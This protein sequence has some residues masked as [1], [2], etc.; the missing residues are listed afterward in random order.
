MGGGTPSQSPHAATATAPASPTVDFPSLYKQEFAYAWRTLRRLGVRERDL[1]DLAHDLF[2]VVFRHLSDYDPA[3]PF[4]PWLFG[5]AY[6]IVSD[7][8]RSARFA[9]ESLGDAADAIDRAPPADEQIAEQQAREQI[10]LVL[11]GLD[12][13]RRAVLVMHDLEGQ[14]VPEIAAALGIPVATAYSRL[15]L[16]REDLAAAIKR[17]RAREERRGA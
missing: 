9:R 12:L 6:R 10:I 13:D 4:R 17:L 1:P 11:D 7:Y 2:I 15:R 16:A 3:R 8:R 14:P 5:F